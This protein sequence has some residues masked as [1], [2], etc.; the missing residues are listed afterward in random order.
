MQS[1]VAADVATSADPFGFS[2]D[3]GISMPSLSGS[4]VYVN[5]QGI[6]NGASFSPPGNPI[7]PGEFVTIFG[8]GLASAQ[9]VASPPY[10]TA[11]GGVLVTVNGISAPIYL[12]SPTQLNI[13][14]P[15]AVTGTTA[16]IVVTNNGVPSNSAVVPLAL[17]APGV[18]S[19][20]SS[21]VGAGV[22]VHSNNSLVT[23]S[24]PAKRGE[25]VSIYLTGLGAVTPAVADGTAGQ[26]SPLSRCNETVTVAIENVNAAVS[27]AGLAPG[28][29]GLYQ[30]NTTIPGGL[31]SSGNMG[32]AV[33]TAEAFAQ[34]ITIAIQ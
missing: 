15:Y 13:L 20:D 16:T 4:G 34:H 22:V 17:T 31:V 7:A 25:A 24:N 27:Y 8:S 23:T 1:F 18:F 10:S 9:S 21:G 29:P 33:T 28:F 32:L 3:F 11:L 6:L 5:P 12:A 2:I 14:V 30:I 19:Q 26:S